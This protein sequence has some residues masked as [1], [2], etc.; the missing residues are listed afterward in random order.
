MTRGCTL[1]PADHPSPVS[2]GPARS[3]GRAL[4]AFFVLAF[5]LSWG[6]VIPLAVSH[7]VVD[8]GQG[9]PTH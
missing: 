9:W 4:V 3:G 7:L 2:V 8:R 6:M 1:P 5:A